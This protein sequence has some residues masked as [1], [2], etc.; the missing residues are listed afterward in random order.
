MVRSCDFSVVRQNNRS[1]RKD[2]TFIHKFKRF[3][4][5]NISWQFNITTHNLNMNLLQ[6]TLFFFK[7]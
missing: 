4:Y 5:L 3:S 1:S 6:I 7:Y 2:R